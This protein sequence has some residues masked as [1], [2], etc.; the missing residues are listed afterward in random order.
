MVANVHTV[1][2]ALWNRDLRAAQA[3]ADLSLP[4]GRPLSL[5]AKLLGDWEARQLRGPDLLME[6]AV[7]GRRLRLRHYYLGGAPGVAEAVAAA[8]KRAAPGLVVAGAWSPPMGPLSPRAIKAWAARLK[9]AR[10]DLV[11][12]GLGAP[13]QEILMAALAEAGLRATMIGVGAAFDYH[14]GTKR[15]AP[16]WMQA[17]ALEWLYR[18]I[19]EPK[20]LFGRY[21]ST[22]PAFVALVLVECLGLLPQSRQGRLERAG[23][24]GLAALMAAALATGRGAWALAL[25]PGLLAWGRLSRLVFPGATVSRGEHE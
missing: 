19:Q 1:V 6:A 21:L 2:S 18:L 17:A 12:V 5:A 15:E 25:V 7:A 10:P 22:N 23:R 8:V 3:D 4:D 13:K 9:R 14:A 20:R 11:W 24:L 16:R